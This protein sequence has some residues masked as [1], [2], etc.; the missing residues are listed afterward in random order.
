MGAEAIP[1]LTLKVGQPLGNGFYRII[2][3]GAAGKQPRT[4]STP[5]PPTSS[6]NQET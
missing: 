4:R 6:W 3:E 2:G 1:G 5:S